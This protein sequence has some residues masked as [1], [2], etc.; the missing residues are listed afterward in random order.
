M[1]IHSIHHLDIMGPSLV[2]LFFLPLPFSLASVPI[3]SQNIPQ[4][5]TLNALEP[6]SHDLEEHPP[7]SR[8]KTTLVPEISCCKFQRWA[9]NTHSSCKPGFLQYFSLRSM[10]LTSDST[11][12]LAS[13]TY[14]IMQA[15]PLSS[16]ILSKSHKKLAKTFWQTDW[17]LISSQ[18]DT[19]SFFKISS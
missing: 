4:V 17:V 7:H 8:Q 10:R 5:R 16:K 19:T 3:L 1:I 14:G 2:S 13:F 11:G 18:N 12:C 6:N 15:H 9:E